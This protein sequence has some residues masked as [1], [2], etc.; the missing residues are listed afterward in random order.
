VNRSR[1][2]ARSARRPRIAGKGGFVFGGEKF[3]FAAK[4]GFFGK[5]NIRA[6]VCRKIK[7]DFSKRR[8]FV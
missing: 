2:A 5:G 3:L 8:V 1:L 4:G 7:A 6:V